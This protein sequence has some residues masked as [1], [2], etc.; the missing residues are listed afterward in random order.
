MFSF[1]LSSID[2]IN[3]VPP[4]GRGF[5]LVACALL[6][7]L[8][9]YVRRSMRSSAS[10]R[11]VRKARCLP[12]SRYMDRRERPSGVI[13]SFLEPDALLR[14]SRAFSGGLPR[15]LRKLDAQPRDDEGAL[16]AREIRGVSAALR[17]RLRATAPTDMKALA[18]LRS[19]QH[20]AL[21]AMHA[22]RARTSAA[23]AVA[24]SH[25]AGIPLDE[26]TLRAHLR[27]CADGGC[28][29][30]AMSCLGAALAAGAPS[31]GVREFNMAIEAL[32]VGGDQPR[33][34]EVLALMKAARPRSEGPDRTTIS[35][36]ILGCSSLV[37]PHAS[38]EL[39]R[40]APTKSGGAGS[41]PRA[42]DEHARVGR[43]AAAGPPGIVGTGAGGAGT[44][45]VAAKKARKLPMQ[46]SSS[47]TKRGA[48]GDSPR[49]ADEGAWQVADRHGGSQRST[50]TRTLLD[51]AKQ[52]ARG[53]QAPQ[54]ERRKAR[55]ARAGAAVAPATGRG[56]PGSWPA[57]AAAPPAPAPTSTSS[58]VDK[59][60]RRSGHWLGVVMR[61]SKISVVLD[62]D[63]VRVPEVMLSQPNFKSAMC[64]HYPGCTF[65]AKCH[66]AHGAEQ[67]QRFKTMRIAIRSQWPERRRQLSAQNF[68][69]ADVSAV[70]QQQ[71]QQQQQQAPQPQVQPQ[72][73]PPPELPQPQRQ[74]QRQRQQ[75]PPQQPQQQ[76]QLPT[77]R[78]P[79][80]QPQRPAQRPVQHQSQRQSQRQPV[81]LPMPM[82][83]GGN[84]SQAES[85]SA[86]VVGAP[87]RT[88]TS[89]LPFGRGSGSGI[90]A[91]APQPMPAAN[92]V[93]PP[94]PSRHTAAPAGPRVMSTTLLQM[95]PS[96]PD[97]MNA[98]APAF[99]PT[100]YWSP[101]ASPAQEVD[102]SVARGGVSAQVQA[103]L[104]SNVSGGSA[105]ANVDWFGEL[106]GGHAPERTRNLSPVG[107][108]RTLPSATRSASSLAEEVSNSPLT[109]PASPPW[110]I[111]MD[112]AHTLDPNP[113]ALFDLG[114]GV[115]LDPDAARNSA[116]PSGGGRAT[117]PAALDSLPRIPSRED[118]IPM[119]LSFL[120]LGED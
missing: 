111:G 73:Q 35:L 98:A 46:A 13:V 14:L 10:K 83:L 40:E 116:D 76:R 44:A 65:G 68:T 58:S 67:Q 41:A 113:P 50:S 52:A 71:Q 32:V 2:I 66:F 49:S 8:V 25:A 19:L 119:D 64:R 20:S 27:G 37:G 48:A 104:S 54:Q 85:F 55:G 3:P 61:M 74:R 22:A 84:V 101:S 60:M 100:A 115:D 70:Q 28:G 114:R 109:S 47:S 91:V 106:G 86:D 7:L 1:M 88:V 45:R 93:N 75:Q 57:T 15:F 11:A 99:R 102:G 12:S 107:S 21:R 6:L 82:A 79:Q 51:Q 56:L 29:A 62:G 42:G 72:V 112:Y 39:L 16:D 4:G 97:P 17:R 34:A 18:R 92:P 9:G 31:L 108:R 24:E 77:P 103:S 36:V 26:R 87:L 38:L 105:G 53:A 89:T 80:V 118:F 43:D 90:F 96:A 110:T 5:V 78:Q 117:G 30:A 63:H 33:I 69:P 120:D 95:N 59:A 81:L 23:L 94:H